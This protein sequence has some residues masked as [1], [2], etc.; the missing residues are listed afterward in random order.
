MI[1]AV[2]GAGG[3]GGNLGGLLARGA[4][5]V[6]LIVRGAHLEA[7]RQNGLRVKMPQDEFT[8]EVHATNEPGEIGPVDLALYGQD[9]S[10][11]HCYRCDAAHGRRG[12]H[13]AQ[14]TEWGRNLR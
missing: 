9:L 3:I 1:I 4:N 13:C 6:S 2:M 10:Q 8:A 5:D 12:H 14:P 7:I 11:C